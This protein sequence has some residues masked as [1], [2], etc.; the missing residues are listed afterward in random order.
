[1]EPRRP[2]AGRRRGP[3][4]AR[5]LQLPVPLRVLLAP[6]EY[7]QAERDRHE[8]DE[9]QRPE[10]APERGQ[11]LALEDRLPDPV[12]RIRRGRDLRE[13]PRR[14]SRRLPVPPGAS[15]ARAAP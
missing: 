5:P 12:E 6:L 1:R 11:A 15:H 9:K 14:R 4:S 10:V 13:P 7:P 2:C 8:P 3:P